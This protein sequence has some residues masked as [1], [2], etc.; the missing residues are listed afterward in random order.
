MQCMST[1][2]TRLYK[3]IPALGIVVLEIEVFIEVKVVVVV[4]VVG[5]LVVSV[6]VGDVTYPYSSS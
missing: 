6:V 4:V 3:P 1:L 2:S 5:I